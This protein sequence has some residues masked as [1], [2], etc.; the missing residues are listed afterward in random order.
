MKSDILKLPNYIGIVQR[1]KFQF[2]KCIN[3]NKNLTKDFI[4]KGYIDQQHSYHDGSYPDRIHVINDNG[5]HQAYDPKRFKITKELS[6]VILMKKDNPVPSLITNLKELI[7]EYDN[8]EGEN[9][10]IQFINLVK[11]LVKNGVE[12]DNKQP[13]EVQDVFKLPSM[14]EIYEKFKDDLNGSQITKICQLIGEIACTPTKKCECNHYGF[15]TKSI[16]SECHNDKV[17]PKEGATK[18]C[19]SCKTKIVLDDYYNFGCPH[20]GEH[21]QK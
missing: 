13:K 21:A 8:S 20:C 1:L 16:C 19:I 17:F 9:L 4:Y 7:E 11:K 12:T 3:P 2:F 5:R 14:I 10:H 6:E 15:Y 18:P